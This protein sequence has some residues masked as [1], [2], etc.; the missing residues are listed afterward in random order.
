LFLNSY[1]EKAAAQ[2][3]LDNI[4]LKGYQVLILSVFFFVQP[5]SNTNDAMEYGSMIVG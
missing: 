4:G 5:L 3:I 1:E 2:K